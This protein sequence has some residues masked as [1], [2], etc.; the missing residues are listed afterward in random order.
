MPLP[1]DVQDSLSTH[2]VCGLK[3]SS[4]YFEE[5][6]VLPPHL[7]SAQEHC[8]MSHS[9][10]TSAGARLSNGCRDGCGG[11]LWDSVDVDNGVL[12]RA[13]VSNRELATLE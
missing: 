2:I 3:L 7:Q 12:V 4:L 1:V 10:P 6:F 13:L 11:R 8:S 5:I 9:S